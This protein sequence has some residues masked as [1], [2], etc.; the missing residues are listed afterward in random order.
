[1]DE[2]E[3]STKRS[4]R[5]EKRALIPLKFTPRF[6]QDSDA[7]IAT[8]KLIKRRVELLRDHAGGGESYQREL[9]CQRVAFLS[10]ILETAEVRAAEDGE[11]D[12][13]V[14]TQASNTLMGFLKTLGLEKRIKNVSDLKSY[15]STKEK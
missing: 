13:P 6:W 8:V 5:R 3:L 7:R 9:L 1:M 10:I 12:L 14:Y 4:K 11:L 2:T 15:L